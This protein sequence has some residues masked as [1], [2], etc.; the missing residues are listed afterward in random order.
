MSKM[1]LLRNKILDSCCEVKNDFLE[2][3]LHTQKSK[4]IHSEIENDDDDRNV[5]EN[6]EKVFISDNLALSTQFTRK[7]FMHFADSLRKFKESAHYK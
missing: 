5:R 7:V 4:E 3:R 2:A 6:V 1:C